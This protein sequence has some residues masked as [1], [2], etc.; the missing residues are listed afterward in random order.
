MDA[1][2]SSCLKP[3][4]LDLSSTSPDEVMHKAELKKFS[5]DK[6]AVRPVQADPS[7]RLIPLAA[8]QFGR[9][10]WHFEAFLTELAYH[11]VDRPSGCHLLQVEGTFA[12]CLSIVR[13]SSLRGV[14]G[15]GSHGR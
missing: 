9:R 7:M 15:L 14:G 1:T 12:I 6:A 5:D 3:S 11:L 4:S 2:T 13:L 8:N 10:G